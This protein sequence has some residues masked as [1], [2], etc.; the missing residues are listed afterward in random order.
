MKGSMIS[1]MFNPPRRTA[2][3]GWGLTGT[4]GPKLRSQSELHD[5]KGG[6]CT[7]FEVHCCSVQVGGGTGKCWA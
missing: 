4:G 2:E 3:L 5:S 1:F 7:H 6:V